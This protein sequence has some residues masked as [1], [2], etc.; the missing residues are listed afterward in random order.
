MCK[1]NRKKG[2][3]LVELM[4]VIA[5]MVILAATATPVFSGY[6]RRAKAAEYLTQCRAIYV[7][8]EVYLEGLE[9]KPES[10]TLNAEEMEKEIASLTG[11]ED[12]KFCEGDIP[13]SK[14]QV[15]PGYQFYVED[16]VCTAVIY[17]DPE[18]GTW[19]FNVEDGTF[20]EMK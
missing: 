4:V 10:R 18:N 7:G 6:I 13:E 14:G 9:E 5:I 8:V 16:G 2:F 20:T 15:E 11:V 12:V 1:A 17:Q 3:T 19:I